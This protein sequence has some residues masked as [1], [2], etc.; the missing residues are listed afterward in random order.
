MYIAVED[1]FLTD[2]LAVVFSQVIG[3]IIKY[4]F[5]SFHGMTISTK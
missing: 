1:L 2:D 4:Y 5:A 3:A